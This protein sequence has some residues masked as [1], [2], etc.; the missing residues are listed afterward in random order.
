MKIRR[1]LHF[2]KQTLTLPGSKS[3]SNRALIIQALS[4]EKISIDNLSNSDD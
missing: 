2:Q 3:E 1:P 4:E